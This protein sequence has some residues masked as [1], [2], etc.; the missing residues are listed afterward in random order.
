MSLPLNS[1]NRRDQPA[2]ATFLTDMNRN[3]LYQSLLASLRYGGKPRTKLYAATSGMYARPNVDAALEK[4]RGAGLVSFKWNLF[5]LTKKDRNAL[6]SVTTAISEMG[7][8]KPPQVVRRAGSC[9]KHIASR[10]GDALVY[11]GRI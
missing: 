8:W 5:S 3:G 4:L 7:H 10:Y 2:G 1:G 6:P 9:T 11:G